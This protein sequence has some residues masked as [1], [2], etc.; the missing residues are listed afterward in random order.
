M[1][2]R[3]L[4]PRSFVWGSAAFSRLGREKMLTLSNHDPHGATPPGTA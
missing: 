1:S 4:H 2:V 3:R